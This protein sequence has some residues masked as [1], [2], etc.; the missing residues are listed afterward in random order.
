[1][2][3]IILALAALTLAAAMLVGGSLAWRDYTQHKTNETRGGEDVLYTVKLVEDYTERK[4][5]KKEQGKVDKKIR[6]T[7]DGLTNGNYGTSYVRLQLKDYMEIGKK[8]QTYTGV[9][10][11]IDTNGNFVYYSTQEA[12]Q[13]AYPGHKVAHL[14]DAIHNI[15]G[16]FIQTQAKDPNGQYGAFLCTKIT[17][18]A[19]TSVLPGYTRA[20]YEADV[21]HQI[22][23][24]GECAYHL[25]L[26]DDAK[27]AIDDYVQVNLGHDVVLLAD[28]DGKPT[29]KWILAPDG[30]IYWGQALKPGETSV[31]L[32]ESLELLKNPEGTFYYA[33]HV[34]MQSVSKDKLGEWTDMPGKIDDSYKGGGQTTSNG[35]TSSN[36][37]TLIEQ[38]GNRVL[39]TADSVNLTSPVG[40]RTTRFFTTTGNADD[41]RMTQANTGGTANAVFEPPSAANHMAYDDWD[42]RTRQLVIPHGYVGAVTIKVAGQYTITVNVKA[43]DTKANPQQRANSA[44]IGETFEADGV[45]WRV[46]MKDNTQALIYAEHALAFDTMSLG[47]SYADTSFYTWMQGFYSKLTELP[48]YNLEKNVPTLAGDYNTTSQYRYNKLRV[49]PLSMEETG[50]RGYDNATIR[51]FGASSPD[52]NK[53]NT[54]TAAERVNGNTVIFGNEYALKQEKITGATSTAANQYQPNDYFLRTPGLN[55]NAL[56]NWVSVTPYGGENGFYMNGYRNHA[57]GFRPAMFVKL[58]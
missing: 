19:A 17:D 44:R 38:V 35:S 32:V 33:L 53:I 10:Y 31:N 27:T 37:I 58:S 36:S 14:T 7:N 30:W 51:D 18:G 16:W 21:N 55:N 25:K 12:A 47:S 54:R 2:K 3:K 20:D 1:M 13:T 45:E 42:N 28:W 23:P 4:N 50:Y 43:N 34:D 52:P 5:W 26:W 29:A 9:R 8:Q 22:V 6:V 57:A 46:L 24:N 41:M 56:S 39:S 48:P 11:M 15:T 49:F 40:Q